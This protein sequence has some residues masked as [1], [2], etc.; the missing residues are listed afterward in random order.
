N[1][2]ANVYLHNQRIGLVEFINDDIIEPLAKLIETGS[3]L[4]VRPFRGSFEII[5]H[6]KFACYATTTGAKRT[7]TITFAVF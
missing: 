5:P 7:I 2:T 6:P 4:M 1:K 3:D